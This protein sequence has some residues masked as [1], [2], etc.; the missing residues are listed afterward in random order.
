MTSPLS[1]LGPAIELIGRNASVL[2]ATG[3]AFEDMGDLDDIRT[4]QHKSKKCAT[5]IYRFFRNVCKSPKFTR[6]EWYFLNHGDTVD[7]S[8]N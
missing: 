6:Y 4:L 8:K 5:L 3:G 2:P 1:F 7:D